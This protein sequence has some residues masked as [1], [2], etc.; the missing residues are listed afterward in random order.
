M[1]GYNKEDEANPLKDGSSILASIYQQNLVF[2][3]YDRVVQ[4]QDEILQSKI[5]SL[6]AKKQQEREKQQDDETK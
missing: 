6:Q 1:A 3:Q 4:E 5:D 2:D